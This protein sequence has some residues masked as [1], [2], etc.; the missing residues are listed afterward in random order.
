MF[1]PRFC[2]FEIIS[3]STIR[4]AKIYHSLC[5]FNAIFSKQPRSTCLKVQY[6]KAQRDKT[7]PIEQKHH[8]FTKPKSINL[9]D[10]RNRK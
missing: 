5:L 7:V 8:V 3:Y 2:R 1:L 4:K 10:C 9:H 6:G